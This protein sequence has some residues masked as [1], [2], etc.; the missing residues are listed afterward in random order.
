MKNIIIL[1]LFIFLSLAGCQ[2]KEKT[3]ELPTISPYLFGQNLWLTN[4]AEGRHGYIQESLWPKVEASGVK[5]VRIGGNGYDQKLPGLDTLTAWVK[6]IKA[7]GAEPML[8][9]S[10]YETAEKAAS[11]VK[12]F[13]VDQELYIKYWA[14]GNEPYII[15]HV[16]IEEISEYIKKTASAMKAVD[17]SIKIFAPDEAAYSNELYEALLLDDKKSVAGRDDNGNWY[18]D[19]VTFHN[20]PNGKDYN[21]SDVIFYSVSK[22]RN[23]MMNLKADIAMANEKYQRFGDDALMWGLTEFNIT[24]RNPDNLGVEG[25]AV[26]S[27]INGQFWADVF[28]M[29]MEYGA[30]C[31]TP[32]CIQESDRNE[33]YFGYI[34]G[35][36]EF[37]PHSTYYHMQMMAENMQ[38]SYVKIN[39]NH[40]YVK[41]FG[42][43]NNETSTILLMNQSDQENVQFDLR[44]MNQPESQ[45]GL[46]IQSSISIKANLKGTIAPNTTRLYEFDKNGKLIKAL[47]YNLEM[48][49]ENHA[50]KSIL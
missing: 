32:W 7:I 36:P 24:Y 27:F 4:G 47:E 3:I 21:R 44:K 41:A 5:I 18:I 30:F 29:A 38:G 40:P 50:P 25:I 33:T 20:Y 9:V 16:P 26:P 34:S 15:H 35:P 49:G 2:T 22:M 37:T 23:M 14:I 11:V 43:V 17:P 31:V 19:G 8:Q 13:N 12:Y 45:V 48:A 1:S 42:A 10:K 28:G 46:S 39:T 6:S